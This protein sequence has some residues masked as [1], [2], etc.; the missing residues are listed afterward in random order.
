MLFLILPHCENDYGGC[1]KG[2]QNNPQLVIWLIAGTN[3][4]C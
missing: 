4:F 2:S 1:T 3:A